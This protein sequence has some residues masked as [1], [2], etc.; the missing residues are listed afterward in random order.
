MS[1]MTHI[2]AG[3]FQTGRDYEL[4]ARR[5]SPMDIQVSMIDLARAQY[6]LGEFE[7]ARWLAAQVLKVQPLWLTAQT[8]LLAAFWRLGRED[9]AR[10][11]AALL[12]RGHPKFSVARWAN[13]WPYRREED[14]A[15][16]TDPLLEAGLPE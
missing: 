5:L 9:E 10:E 14:L 16:L 11:T 4:Q 6:H 7:G 8:I 1:A 15:A 12:I 3:N 2:Y 13:A